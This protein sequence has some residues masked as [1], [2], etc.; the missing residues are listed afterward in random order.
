MCTNFRT[1]HEPERL[2][3]FEV[4]AQWAGKVAMPASR[5]RITSLWYRTRTTSE[6]AETSAVEQTVPGEEALVVRFLVMREDSTLDWWAMPQR[7]DD[8]EVNSSSKKTLNALGFELIGGMKLSRDDLA[9]RSSEESS[10]WRSRLTIER[11]NTDENLSSQCF[12][13]GSVT[14]RDEVEEII[15]GLIQKSPAIEVTETPTDE[16]ATAPATSTVQT[17]TAIVAPPQSSPVSLGEARMVNANSPNG[18]N[19]DARAL[20]ETGSIAPSWC[21]E[22]LCC[23]FGWE[24]AA[25]RRVEAAALEARRQEQS[26]LIAQRMEALQTAVMQNFE[27]IDQRLKKLETMVESQKKSIESKT[28]TPDG[29]RRSSVVRT[30]S[31][32][33]TSR[34]DSTRTRDSTADNFM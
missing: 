9:Q 13:F 22:T 8:L 10:Q 1:M 27:H 31:S 5:P 6:E 23:C 18:S 28:F 16:A 20:Q 34:R 15:N 19:S 4:P 17:S 7:S 30:K 3:I 25:Q 24:E 26:A 12:A 29:R 11:K 21:L 2:S 33:N 14:E 32:N